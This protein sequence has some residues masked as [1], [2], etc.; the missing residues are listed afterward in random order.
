M[1]GDI[2]V[3]APVAMAIVLALVVSIMINVFK[4][5]QSPQVIAISAPA[6]ATGQPAVLPDG[7]PNPLAHV[8]QNPQDAVGMPDATGGMGQ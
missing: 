3:K 6:G 8:P 5:A 4:F 1:S 2:T 7:R